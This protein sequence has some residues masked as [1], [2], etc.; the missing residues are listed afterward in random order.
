MHKKNKMIS[1]KFMNY[2]SLNIIIKVQ[3][4]PWLT[5]KL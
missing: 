1:D 4:Q 5:N 2:Y 3:L